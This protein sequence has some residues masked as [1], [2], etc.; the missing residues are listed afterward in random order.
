MEKHPE[1]FPTQNRDLAFALALAGVPFAPLEIEGEPTGP[2][3]N[4]YT[5][6]FFRQERFMRDA[7]DASGRAVRR[8]IFAGMDLDACAL[9]C[10]SGRY[11][12][13]FPLKQGRRI[14]GHVTYFFQKGPKFS[15]AYPA[16][17]A[18]EEEKEKAEKEGRPQVVPEIPAGIVAVVMWIASQSEKSFL[19]TPFVNRALT[20]CNTMSGNSRE[21]PMEG[22]LAKSGIKKTVYEGS[23]KVWTAGAS[24]ATKDHLKI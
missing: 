19:N 21:E 8:S 10:A 18:R 13:G 4:T 20:M 2:A 22:E 1:I 16:I 9:A 24:K 15:E 11:P 7:K 23:G 3:S 5:P 14:A 6:A 12:I 17:C